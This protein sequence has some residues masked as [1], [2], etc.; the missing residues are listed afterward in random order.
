MSGAR[1][2]GERP[3]GRSGGTAALR[4]YAAESAKWRH[5]EKTED[6]LLQRIWNLAADVRKLDAALCRI[7]EGNLGDEPWQA[8]YALIQ[9]IAQE[10]YRR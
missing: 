3:V 6:E 2:L 5:G 9:E 4:R 8:N 1:N 10:A 7:A